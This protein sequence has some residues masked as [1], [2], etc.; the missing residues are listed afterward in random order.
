MFIVDHHQQMEEKF[1]YP[2]FDAAGKMSALV[3]VLREQHAAGSQLVG[4]LRGLYAEFSARD[5]EKRRTMESAIH[6][7]SRMYRAHV[8]RE[9]TALFPML[10]RIMPAKAYVELSSAFRKA[11]SDFIGQNGFEET[12]RKLTDYE[13][14]LGIGDLATFTPRAE[15]LR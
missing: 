11:E 12:I 7:F 4:I 6:Q 2:V 5:L 3:G 15:E 13:N 1:I 10:R 14:I 9:D 8:E